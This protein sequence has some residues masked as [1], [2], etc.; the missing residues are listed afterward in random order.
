MDPKGVMDDVLI[1]NVALDEPDAEFSITQLSHLTQIPMDR[2]S[3]RRARILSAKLL[4]PNLVTLMPKG[5]Y[6]LFKAGISK[7]GR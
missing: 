2:F 3:M 5:H 1:L 7:R 4:Q 6:M